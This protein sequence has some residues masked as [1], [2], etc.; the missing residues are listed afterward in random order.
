[1]SWLGKKVDGVLNAADRLGEKAVKGVANLGDKVAG[2]LAAAGAATAATGI[3]V[4][5]TPFL[6]MGALMAE[7]ATAGSKAYLDH[8][9]AK[10]DAD[11]DY[12]YK[13]QRDESSL[14]K[15]S[16]KKSFTPGGYNQGV[17]QSQSRGK[18]LMSGRSGGGR[19]FR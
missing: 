19:S 9:G 8:R 16:K 14:Q 6:E 3:G 17:V 10:K 7:G 18:R 4:V 2:G 5:A 15:K 13:S 1:M 11:G 12:S